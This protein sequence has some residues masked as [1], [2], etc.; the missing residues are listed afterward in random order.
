MRLPESGDLLRV[1]RTA[2]AQFA[3]PI[4]F[5]VIRRCDWP[6]YRGWTWLDGYQLDSAGNAVERRSIFVRLAGLRRVEPGVPPA[7]RYR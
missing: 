1:T 4:L 6:T 5:R 3:V 2:S 7:S